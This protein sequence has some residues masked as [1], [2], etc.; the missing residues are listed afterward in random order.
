MR[1][2]R[3]LVAEL[4]GLAVL[5]YGAG[6]A[7]PQA[8]ASWQHTGWGGGGFFPPAGEARPY[9]GWSCAFH[10]TK[11]GVIY[12]G[13]DV[14]GAYRT[15]D[16][17]LHWRFIPPAGEAR[18]YGG[19]NG[20]VDYGVYSLA[21]DRK[22]PDTVYAG[23]LGGLCKSTDGGAHWEFLPP[24]GEARPY[25]GKESAKDALDIRADRNKSVR[26]VAVDPSN[27]SVVYAGTPTGKI[28]PPYGRGAPA[29]DKSEDGGQSW[30]KLD[31]LRAVDSDPKP[32]AEIPAFSGKG[33]LVLS[34]ESEA[35]NWQP[36]YGRASP[37]GGKNGRAEKPFDPPADW[38]GYKKATA[39][40]YVPTNAPKLQAQLVVQTGENWLWQGGPFV[41]GKRGAWTEVAMPLTGLKEM[42]SVR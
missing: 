22:N 38:S 1:S 39:R 30:R 10:P 7:E 15:D 3:L 29:G 16:K 14:G 18:P 41:D 26:A 23:T 34:F 31:Y 11:D 9:G 17:G 28:F 25:G 5:I 37:A 32:A 6:V 4:A 24:A 13:G 21:V 42:Q 8:G 27:G 20:L 40:F 36:P 35:G 2:K 12:L 33:C 19:N